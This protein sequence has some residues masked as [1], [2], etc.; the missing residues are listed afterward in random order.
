V[1]V[2]ENGPWK[3]LAST[4]THRDGW[5]SVRSDSV[6]R[7]DGS[8]GSYS[9]IQVKPGVCVLPVE[10]EF[11]Y[12][13][14]EFRYAMGKWCL[15]AAS[16]GSER[17]EELLATAQRELKEELGIEAREWTDVG[18]FHANTSFIN[19]PLQLF[20]ARG[21]RVGEPIPDSTEQIR[22]VKMSLS[23]AL[24][25]VMDGTITHGP[26]QV[27]VLKVG[28]TS[29]GGEVVFRSIHGLPEGGAVTR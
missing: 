23:E 4:E 15:E 8:R 21:L 10:G 20:M 19:G 2:T 25:A 7:P 16:G 29:G 13:G 18:T 12:L 22:R 5:F 11:V 3:V 28:L 9:V 24:A 17:E 1:N 27:L 26:T 14:E 6:I